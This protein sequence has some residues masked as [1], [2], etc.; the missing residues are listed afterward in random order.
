MRDGGSKD[1]SGASLDDNAGDI[2]RGGRLRSLREH[3]LSLCAVAFVVL[4]AGVTIPLVLG[5]SDG[6]EEACHQ[7]TA[8]TRALVEDPRAATE[9]LDPGDGLARI[10]SAQ[11]LLRHNSVCGDGAQALG[12]IVDAATG[13]SASGRPHTEAQARAA[14]AVAAAVHG[15]ELPRGLAPGLARMVAEYVVDAGENRGWGGDQLPGPA[16]S[17]EEARPDRQGWSRYGRFLAPGEA[18]TVFGYTDSR[19]EAE[20]DIESLV[21]E[22]SKDP[23]AFAILYDAERANFAHH[24]ERLTDSGGNPDYRTPSRPDSLSKATNGPD[25]DLQHVAGHIGSLMKHRTEYAMDGS[26]PDLAAFDRSVRRHTSGTF[27]P[28]E[29]QLNSRPVMGDIADRPVS[30]PVE[31]DLPDG[32]HQLFSVLE[33]WAKARG[34]PARRAAAMKQLMDDAYVRALWLRV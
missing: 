10:G 6:S 28:A 14:Y 29:K 8:S 34:V 26:I 18:H 17:S 3:R 24:L 9:A 19:P 30:G 20:A 5:G 7:V 11:K 15:L 1:E 12:R 4:A 31:G 21:A 27:R 33:G 22:L 16:V 2:G 25:R 32:R 13:S 23:E